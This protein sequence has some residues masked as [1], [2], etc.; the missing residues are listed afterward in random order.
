VYCGKLYM[1]REEKKVKFYCVPF[2]I[3]IIIYPQ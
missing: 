1:K 2:F 3:I